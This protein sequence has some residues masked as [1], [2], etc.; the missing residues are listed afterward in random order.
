MEKKSLKLICQKFTKS[1]VG[2]SRTKPQKYIHERL[3][4][5]INPRHI[6]R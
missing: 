4:H 3:N 5:A 6:V 2:L 1:Y